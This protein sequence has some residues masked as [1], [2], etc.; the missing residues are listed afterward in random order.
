MAAGYAF[1][2][3]L[4]LP[5]ERRRRVCLAIGAGS[6]ALF[7]LLRTFNIYG[8]PRH[9]SPQQPLSFLNT[10]KYPAS[11]LFLLMTLGPLILLMPAFDRARGAFA[12]A[13]ETFGRVPLF[14]YVLHIPL[15]H[16]A[17]IV[18]SLIRTG[19]VTPWLFGNHP[20]EPPEP[21]EGV[22]VEPDVAV[23]G[24]R[25]LRGPAVRGVSLVRRPEI[26]LRQGFG[27]TGPPLIVLRLAGRR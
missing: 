9:W 10:A 12:G 21:P 17:A 6:I 11:L 13:L 22:S 25:D 18:I 1:G 16:L 19:A 3:V 7:I 20:M 23:S 24:D 4:A 26:R 8:D 27:E 14:Y 2:K 15:I 5:E